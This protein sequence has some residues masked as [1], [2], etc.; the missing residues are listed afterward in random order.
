MARMMFI[1]GRIGRSLA[2][3]LFGFVLGVIAIYTQG[4]GGPPLESWHTEELEAEF[5]AQSADEIRTFDDYR[6]LENTL[7]A[8]VN[9]R[10][11]AHTGTG[12]ASA[13]VRY[14]AGSAADPRGHNPDWN[15]SFELPADAPAGGVLLLHGMSDSPYSLRS[16]GEALAQ[17]D[18]WVLGLRLPGHGT[19]PSGLTG[20]A[21]EDMAAA[22]RLSME[23]LASKVGRKPI[24]M[25]GYSTGAP[26]AL[27][28]ALDALEGNAAPAP[29]S[30]VLISPA[31]GI[32]PA[33][34]LAKW[35]ARLALLPGLERLAWTQVL[36]EFDPYKYNSF[37]TNAADQ[38]HRLTR[39][40]ARRI[41]E[42]ARPAPAETLP[43]LLVFKSTVDATVSTDAVIDGLLAYLPP[44]RNELVLFD[45]NRF[46]AKS[47]LMI[48]DP[49]PLTARL[50]ADE[51]LP[52]A[53][54]LVA[55]ENPESRRVL[56]RH[57]P[58]FSGQESS[59]ERLNLAW[60]V[61]V[62]S[63]SHVALPFSPDDPLY[64]QRPPGNEDVLFLGQMA[65]KGER[66]LLQFPSDWLM[67][68][69]HNPFY[70]YLEARTVKWLDH[71]NQRSVVPDPNG[72]GGD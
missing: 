63:M 3:I 25:V 54:T 20:I 30:L 45:I 49:G 12:P 34:A 4:P 44:H 9:E 6:R 31:I 52:F 61:G 53:I 38:V 5:T 64:G 56:A 39:S 11:Y 71:A 24:H 72:D 37:A 47:T 18:Y 51:S 8:E 67:R 29:A 28:F 32:G 19:V 35:Q 42:R 69:R 62:I 7:F 21:W 26:L 43:P 65:I 41:A 68:L 60:P 27:N 14:S 2:W 70:D 59:R 46:A 58:A 55:N 66:G 1:A 15:R 48:A 36:P 33:A 16:L 57:K 23:H 10:I 40:V 17:R 13:L 22:V 50:M